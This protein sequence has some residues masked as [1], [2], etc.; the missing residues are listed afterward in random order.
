MSYRLIKGWLGFVGWVGVVG[1]V[2]GPKD[3]LVIPWH[4]GNGASSEIDDVLAKDGGL[5][6]VLPLA[7]HLNFFWMDK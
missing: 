4:F 6:H 2:V 1:L 7:V 3:F 5:L